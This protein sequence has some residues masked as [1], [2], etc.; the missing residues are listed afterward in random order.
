LSK[1]LNIDSDEIVFLLADSLF[2][3]N[4]STFALEIIKKYA[5]TT[6]NYW[7]CKLLLLKANIQMDIEK[8]DTA[9][10][11]A[12]KAYDFYDKLK[13]GNERTHI[14]GEYRKT[15]GKLYYYNNQWDMAQEEFLKAE[16][17]FK[18]N[19]DLE[20]QAAVYNNLG[21]I[22]MFKGNW[23]ETEKLYLKSIDL[24]KKRFSLNG[25][26]ICYSNLGSLLE[27]EGKKKKSLYYFK[28]ALAI[29]KLLNDRYNITNIYN[30]IGITYMNMG[31]IEN[32][33]SVLNLS[34][35]TAMNFN[36]FRN[37][38]ASYNNLGA[39]HFKIGDWSKAIKYY[40]DAIDK[41][42]ESHFWE[43]LCQSYNNL[44][45]LHEKREEYNIARE[46]YFK[47]IEL[48]PQITDEHLKAELYGNMGSVL[49]TM[50]NFGEAYRYLVESFDFFKTLDIKDKILEGCLNHSLYFL[51]TNNY[52]SALYY[53]NKAYKIAD[54]L[55]SPFNKGRVFYVNTLLEMENLEVAHELIE[56]SINY[57][58][59]TDRRYELAKADFLL[60]K[61]LLEENDWEQALQL[62]KETKKTV[63]KFNAINFLE[64][65]DNKIQYIH[66]AF[67]NEMKSSQLQDS[68]LNKFYE[69]TQQLN[70][71]TDFDVLVQSALDNL[72]F[73]TEAS[74]GIFDLYPNDAKGNSWEY[75][76]HS[77]E[78]ILEKNKQIFASLMQETFIENE[79][80]NF[81]QPQF[82]PSYNNIVTFN[83]SVRNKSQG[84]VLLYS[85]Q[86][87]HYFTQR[88][89]NLI[90]ALCNQIIVIIEN[91]RFSNLEKS[92]A[93]IRESLNQP[94]SYTNI[95]GKS[96][97][98]QEIYD[99]ID[100][101]KDTPT[102][103]LLEG[104]SGTGKE[105]IAK[106]IHY[107]S[108][109][110]KK[111]LIAQYCGALSETLLESELFGHVKGSFTGASYDK[112]GLFE[113]ADGGTFFLDEVSDVS[114]S[115]QTKL[116]RFLQ[117]GEIKKVGSTTTNIVDVRM[118]CATNV[119]LLEK[120]NKG[121]FR[122]DLYYRL[123]VIKI[124]MPS[125]K[126][127]KSDIPL[128]AIHFLDKYNKKINKKIKGITDEAMKYLSECE[129][130]GNIRQ[131]ENEI[132]RSVTLAENNSF[133]KASDLSSEIFKQFEQ[134]N[135]LEILDKVTLKEAVESL[136]KKMINAA[137]KKSNGNQTQAAKDLGL[138]RQ[139]LIKKIK[140][141]GISRK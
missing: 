95:I 139:G 7:R 128:L 44:G 29:Q 33:K 37:V 11:V 116:L 32:A 107:N 61:I 98:I 105:L 71:I 131:L 13:N 10:V 123:N 80:K 62:L 138:S 84:V 55:D 124:D 100:K 129:W 22:A 113:I 17:A 9:L 73:L 59:K 108:N 92:H 109:R 81:L 15:L 50:H 83:L 18:K 141:F 70:S 16:R 49:T 118:I 51:N 99:L 86:G 79:P 90:S 27:D 43:G 28:K 63:T 64:K 120:V 21:V 78:K 88:M 54:D 136:E 121:E 20:G 132:E 12:H 103:V 94:S 140:R 23:E 38:I 52:E 135:T 48:I 40:E 134:N 76:L 42:K 66:K 69:V 111:P 130:P 46:L 75:H 106:A 122:S 53:L 119:N 102:T 31:D 101:I 24:E 77:G 36:L 35:K 34:L 114:L 97:K 58:S 60:A 74:G 110:K 85:G 82:I 67:E 112:K 47:G 26:S 127:R 137:I 104:P 93:I 19:N 1:K 68:L 30:N 57:F 133:I 125:L 4:S 117:E 91:I 45:E 25:L 56:K 96:D 6:S 14:L 3:I 115:T 89:Q 87:S 65:I 5:L 2:N 8:F 41:S 126:E 39:L 72:I